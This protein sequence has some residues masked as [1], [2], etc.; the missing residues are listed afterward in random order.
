MK[1]KN[2]F[3]ITM[4]LLISSGVTV[5]AQSAKIP[6]AVDV[7]EPVVKIGQVAVEG[8]IIFNTKEA[9]QSFNVYDMAGKIIYQ[10][11]QTA[12]P[13]VD[14]PVNLRTASTGIYVAVAITK[15]NKIVKQKIY[16]Q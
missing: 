7:L 13:F 14:T 10:I 4:F 8:L 5:F 3:F 12:L 16:V 9:L 15:S 1:R 11:D 6:N 2:L